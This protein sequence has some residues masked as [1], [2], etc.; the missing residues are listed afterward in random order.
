MEEKLSKYLEA[1]EGINLE[2]KRCGGKVEK[3]VFETLCSFANRQGGSIL[4]GVLDDGSAPGVSPESVV[5]LERNIVNVVNNPNLFNVAPAIEFER[6]GAESGNVVL[7]V[8][9]PMGPALYSFKGV[10]YDRVADVDAKVKT[11]A[12]RAAMIIRKQNYYTEKTVYPW[13]TEDDL[14][15]GALAVVRREVRAAREDHPWLSLDDGELLRAARLYSRDPATGER[16]FNLA[17]VMLLGRRET[18]L[19]VAPVY[20]T[21]VVLSRSG[22]ERY[23]DRLVCTGNLVEA[24][25]EISAF[26]RKWLPD[27][28]ALGSD[29][30]R[31]SVRD[32]IVRELVANS[33]IHREYT[34]PHIA[35]ITID[36]DGIITRNASRALYAGPVTL[37]NLD[38]TPKNPVIANFFT[39]M[40]RSEELG[41]GVRNLYGCSEL[42]TGR[43]PVMTDGDFFEA[44]VPV[45]SVG[46]QVAGSKSKQSGRRA[47]GPTKHERTAAE[48]SATV[49]RLLEDRGEV[50]ASEVSSEMATLGERTVRR[51]LSEMVADGKLAT[52]RRGRSTVYWKPG[53]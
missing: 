25:G 22:N 46:V 7:R 16:G 14:D 34:S 27:A 15:L 50:A 39:Q 37:D 18:I 35:R 40:G 23:D 13:V 3:D 31:V 21:D 11:D 43:T 51:Y 32:V 29:G 41:S 52:E 20:R 12:Q 45:P 44:F 38:P 47:Q 53:Q 5:S 19:D 30:N 33:L 1:G 24:Y 42:Y 49:A 36:G 9:V 26:C 48:V 4:L 28:F 8:W 6:L 17:A 2:F 10:V